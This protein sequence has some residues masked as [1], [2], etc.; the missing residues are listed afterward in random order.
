MS[1]LMRLGTAVT[2]I[3]F[4]SFH[5]KREQ[6][7]FSALSACTMLNIGVVVIAII[8]KNIKTNVSVLF[9]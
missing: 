3:S 9:L 7:I 1:V 5:R 6:S 4:K 2:G 8:P